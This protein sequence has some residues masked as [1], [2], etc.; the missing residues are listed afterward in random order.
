MAETQ[1][2]YTFISVEKSGSLLSITMRRPERRNALNAALVVELT[3]AFSK[4]GHDEEVRVI[5]LLGEGEAFSAGADLDYLQSLQTNTF[6]EN[7]ADSA[8]L[9]ALF[10]EIYDSPKVTIAELHGHA[11]A[12]GCGLATVT[13]F[14]FAVPEAM[15]GYTEVKIGFIPAIVSVYLIKKI[16]AH[17]AKRLL[18]TGELITAEEAQR[19]GLLTKVIDRTLIEGHVEDFARKLAK[20]TSPNSIASTKALLREV[21]GLS[22]EEGVAK[23]VEANA[24]ARASADCKRGI[25]AFLAKEKITWS[26]EE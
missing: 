19:L 3:D 22:I 5:R 20:E 8:Q 15:L 25:A 4:A 9:A 24:S 10:K 23:A 16:P 21:D 13:D 12:G 6:E 17:A 26:S 11:I 1:S 7:L 14:T 18:L 2:N